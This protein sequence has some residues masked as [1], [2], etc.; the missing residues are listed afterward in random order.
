MSTVPAVGSPGV[1]SPTIEVTPERP[2]FDE[3]VDIRLFDVPPAA[4]VTLRVRTRLPDGVYASNVVYQADDR[5]VVD[6]ATA[7]PAD[8]TADRPAP[9]APFWA[10]TAVDRRSAVP[11]TTLVRTVETELTVELDGEP[12]TERT[13]DRQLTGATVR[14]EFLDG[15]LVGEIWLPDE[16]GT[17]PGVVL[18]GGSEGG[19][20]PRIPA[21]VLA[22]RGYA[23]LA[24]AYFGQEGLPPTLERIDL[25]Y[26]DR[27][28]DRFRSHPNVR[29]E[30]I[31]VVGFS[32]G[33]ELGLE[34]AA[35]DPTITTAIAY[36]PS[37]VRFH[38]V[39]D[40]FRAPEPAWVENGRPRPSVP[41]SVSLRFPIRLFGSLLR[42][43]PFPLAPLYRRAIEDASTATIEAA[44]IDVDSI[45]GPVLL[46]SGGDDR[47]W[48]ADE[49]ARELTEGRDHIEHRRFP[50]AGHAI[51]VPYRPLGGSTVGPSLIPGVPIALG[52]QPE[53]NAIASES[54]WH[55]TLDTLVDGLR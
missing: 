29:P 12:V 9:M 16:V 25:S 10:M 24:P 43:S 52:G 7:V 48:P 6:L 26:F 4:S 11:R 21:G 1:V 45:D 42:R 28:I 22:A 15:D 13:I 39:P 40:G 41:L 3:P 49:F 55:A 5:G 47:L 30:P 34:L 35:R 23:V 50:G 37:H 33:A 2:L 38:G 54:A 53:T 18:L 17:H 46:V 19:Y 8:D 32:R 27:A 44:R 36:A 14:R 31:G 20:P 51:G